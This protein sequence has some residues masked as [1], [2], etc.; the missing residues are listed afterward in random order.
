[1][2]C[3]D[4]Q[5]HLNALLDG[6]L[7]AEETAALTAHLAVCPDCAKSLA[8]LARLRA[9]L[10]HA[11]PEEEVSADL[12]MRVEAALDAEA[13][14]RPA[15]DI[16]PF[17]RRPPARRL[18][19]IGAGAA[20]AAGL[21]IALLPRDDKSRDLMAVRDATLRGA[22]A[23][24]QTGPAVPAVRGFQFAS[25]RM[26]VVAGHRSQVLVYKRNGD[27]ITLCIWP[28]NGEPAHGVRKTVY[29]NTAIS[30]WNDGKREFWAASA[31][32]GGAALSDFVRALTAG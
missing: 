5:E 26:D 18:A 3:V 6:E 32:P 27:T 7:S 23:Q 30:Y 12:L 9:A 15:H 10:T 21:T 4:R 20:I 22:L 13:A 17:R 31:E 28:A 14:V 19:W 29:Q 11:I 25:A 24:L 1:M 16:I 8:G 2:S